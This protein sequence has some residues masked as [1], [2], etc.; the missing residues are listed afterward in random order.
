MTSTPRLALPFLV[1]GQAQK[2]FF[3]NEALQRLDL[4]VQPIVEVAASNAPPSSPTL[5][6][7]FLVGSVPT[8]AW[9]G[10]SQALAGWTEGGWR[11]VLPF[12]GMRVGDRSSGQVATFAT[13]TWVMGVLD[14]ASVRIGG[15]AVLGARRP[16]IAG[17]TAGGVQDIEARAALNSVLS[18]LRGHGLITT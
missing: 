11:F 1:P 8:G 9:A 14:V 13:G 17:P 2:E 3:H 18:T 6:Q 12:E 7:C 15:V 4:A 5:G 16:A 10:Q